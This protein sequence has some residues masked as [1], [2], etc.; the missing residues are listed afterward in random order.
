M[1]QFEDSEICSIGM[2]HPSNSRHSGLS[3]LSGISQF[4]GIY[5]NFEI[6]GLRKLKETLSRQ[7]N[8]ILE[9][10]RIKK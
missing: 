4:S 9:G 7:R 8:T 10:Y 5:Y 2:I 3:M 6:Y 1:W